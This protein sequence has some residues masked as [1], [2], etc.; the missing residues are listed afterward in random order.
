MRTS[1]FSAADF[2]RSQEEGSSFCLIAVV[3]DAYPMAVAEP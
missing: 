2:F 1:G 3:D